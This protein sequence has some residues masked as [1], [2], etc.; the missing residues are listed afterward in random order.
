VRQQGAG[1]RGQGA[2]QTYNGRDPVLVM[3]AD[4]HTQADLPQPLLR[5]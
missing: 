4:E 1:G 3:L 2:R 5:H